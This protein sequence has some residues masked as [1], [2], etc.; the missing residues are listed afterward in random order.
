MRNLR[1]GPSLRRHV[2]FTLGGSGCPVQHEG[3]RVMKATSMSARVFGLALGLMLILSAIAA[4]ASLARAACNSDPARSADIG[5]VQSV[6]V[7]GDN[8]V[9]RLT[10]TNYGPCG[11]PNVGLHVTLPAA[12]VSYSSNPNSWTCIGSLDVTCWETSTIGVPGTADIYLVYSQGNAGLITACAATFAGTPPPLP[13]DPPVSP[14]GWVTGSVPDLLRANNTSTVAAG[15]LGPGI[16]LVY[17]PGGEPT[18]NQGFDHTT[19]VSLANGGLVNI[20]QADP[21]PATVP[22]CFLGTITINFT[23]VSGAKT[24]TLEF[25]ASKA[26]KKSLSQI[27]IWNSVGGAFT[28]LTNCGG[29]HPT[30]PCVQSRSRSTNLDGDTVYTIIVVGTQDNGMT[31]D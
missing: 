4:P 17:G 30:D 2:G 18:P 26:G 5:L 19:T 10:V 31:A 16:P 1:Y 27:T 12:L 24:W 29:K 11:V 13:S 28:A 7:S 15:L 25:L 20:Y 3:D 22:N 21:C 6:S 14:C 8:Y 23:N 9:D